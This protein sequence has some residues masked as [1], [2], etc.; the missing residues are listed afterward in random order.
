MRIAAL[1]C[2]IAFAAC[3][4]WAQAPA[5][6]DCGVV[7]S[8]KEIQKEVGAKG[9]DESKPSGLVATVPLG[10]GAGKP[11]VGPSQR[12]GGDT[13][14]STKRWEVVV[15]LDDGRAR[16]LTLDNQPDVQVG[17]KVRIDNGR[18]LPRLP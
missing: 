10:P 7:R 17:D 8:V 2:A 13:I 6:K 9:T 16:I 1:F 14:A 15:L 12:V 4:A 11:R 5:C 18:I 3:G